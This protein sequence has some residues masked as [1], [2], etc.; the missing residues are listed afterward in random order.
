M[1]QA[2]A[3]NLIKDAIPP[4]PQPQSWVDL[5]CGTGVFTNALANLLPSESQIFAVDAQSQ[6]FPNTMGNNVSIDFI[7]SDFEKSD[8][9][10]TNLDGILMANSLH[11]IKDKTALIARLEKYLN[12]NKKFIIVEYDTKIANQWVPFPVCFSDLKALFMQ[13]NY[14]KI[15]KI[16]EQKSI[17]GQGNL[18]A[19]NI[20]F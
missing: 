14:T 7:K 18:Y 9:D 6:N 13:Y 17:F 4:S 20:Q 10:F 16:S 5:G 8:F 15:E 12:E 19:A 2:V 11:F 1:T 3:I